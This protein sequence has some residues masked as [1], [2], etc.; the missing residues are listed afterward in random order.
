M[1]KKLLMT[2]LFFAA[3]VFAGESSVRPES[4]IP[5]PAEEMGNSKE[6]R[7]LAAKEREDWQ[8]MRA[9]RKQ[10]REQIL[11][12]L[13]E[14]PPSERNQMRQNGLKNRDERPRFEGE[15]P[16][17]QP[18]ER[19][20]FDPNRGKGRPDFKDREPMRDKPDAPPSKGGKPMGK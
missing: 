19:E 13:R 20:M 4:A 9:E 6:N 10:A 11:S 12:K 14:A 7:D 17:N 3:M 8:R 5:T 2:V 1:M 15:F 16:K 18:R